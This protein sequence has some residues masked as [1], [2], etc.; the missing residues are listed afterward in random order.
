MHSGPNGPSD[1]SCVCSTSVF[2]DCVEDRR[3]SA[4]LHIP[5]NWKCYAPRVLSPSE[6]QFS[7]WWKIRDGRSEMMPCRLSL[8]FEAKAFW[9][10]KTLSNFTTEDILRFITRSRMK[11][12]DFLFM[13]QELRRVK[14]EGKF[15]KFHAGIGYFLLILFR[16]SNMPVV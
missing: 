10:E 15:V 13:R 3:R 14:G 12:G 11:W 4:F 8:S 2:L 16:I 5:L 9:E 7:W 6:R 1:S